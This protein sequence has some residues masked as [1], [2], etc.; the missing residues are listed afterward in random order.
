MNNNIKPIEKGYA[1][2]GALPTSYLMSLSYE[3][4][5]MKICNKMDEIVK[6]LHGEIDKQLQEYIDERF[7]DIMLDTMYDA[8]TETLVLYLSGSNVG[9]NS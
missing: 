4:Q 3:E 2:I 7:N 9:G 6:F 5:I 1:S 8:E